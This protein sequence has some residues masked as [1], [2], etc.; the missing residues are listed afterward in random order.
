MRG[1]IPP[2]IALVAA[3]AATVACGLPPMVSNTGYRGTWGRRSAFGQS[4]VAIVEHNGRWRLRWSTTSL[5]GKDTV[6]C[7]WDGRCEER[8]AGRL[9][10][11][12]TITTRYDTVTNILAADTVEERLSPTKMTLRYSEVAE[13]DD[14]GRTLRLRTTERGGQHFEGTA[15]P[16]RLFTK[17][18]DSVAFPSGA[19]RR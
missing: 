10:A 8:R 19:D 3:L 15:R 9:L 1:R 13:L 5:D 4:I 14:A 7:D 11:T 2:T 18:A 12:Y 17:L 6:R 16:Q